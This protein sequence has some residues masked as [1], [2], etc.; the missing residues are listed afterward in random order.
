MTEIGLLPPRPSEAITELA[1]DH[2]HRSLWSDVWHQF[3]RH[4]GALVG[5]VVLT[6]I[7]LTVLAG[8]HLW[9][10]SPDFLNPRFA[11]RGMSLDHPFGTDN[12]GRDI[13]AQVM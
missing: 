10:I 12:I 11:N 8:P 5:V 1:L 2:T 7:I 13:F 3:I 6:A 4:K 9:T